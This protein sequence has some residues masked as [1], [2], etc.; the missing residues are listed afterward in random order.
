MSLEGAGARSQTSLRPPTGALP[1]GT[2]LSGQGKGRGSTSSAAPIPL[3]PMPTTT[4]SQLVQ[5]PS[6]VGA[7]PTAQLCWWHSPHQPAHTEHS[8]AVVQGDDNH[9]PVAGQDAAVYHVPCAFHVRATMDIHHHRLGPAVPDV[10]KERWLNTGPHQWPQHPA[11]QAD[12]GQG[13]CQ[14]PGPGRG[15]RS[16]TQSSPGGHSMDFQS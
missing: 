7:H 3:G 9:I 5:A 10:W 1:R 2:P 16:Q 6:A 11:Q 15:L 4:L 13:Q 14:L 8:N 12:Q